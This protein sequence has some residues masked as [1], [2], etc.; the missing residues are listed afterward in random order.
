M[1][2]AQAAR[3]A[4]SGAVVCEACLRDLRLVPRKISRKFIAFLPYGFFVGRFRKWQCSRSARAHGRSDPEVRGLHHPAAVARG[5]GWP[6]ALGSI[7]P[8]ALAAA[9]R[10]RISL[11]LSDSVRVGIAVSTFEPISPRVLAKHLRTD[12]SSSLSNPLTAG[13]AAF[14]SG[15]IL[16]RAAH[17]LRRTSASLFLNKSARTGTAAGPIVPKASEA[18]FRVL[19]SSSLSKLVRAEMA[20]FASGQ[21]VQCPLRS[22][23]RIFGS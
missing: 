13:T 14:A 12:R 9:S 2:A 17:A 8:N 18:A 23:N 15:P 20:V 16:P 21:C 6:F 11:S 10:T 7:S 5:Q 3:S 1:S 4:E 22:G 19:G